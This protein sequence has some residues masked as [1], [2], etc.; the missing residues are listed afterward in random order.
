VQTVQQEEGAV[1][2]V[3]TDNHN[4]SNALEK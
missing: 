4:D 3:M 2:S 1:A